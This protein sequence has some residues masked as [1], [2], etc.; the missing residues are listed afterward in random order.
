MVKPEAIE[1]ILQR[2]GSFYVAG[3]AASLPYVRRRLTELGKPYSV[4]PSYAPRAIRASGAQHECVLICG[5][6][7]RYDLDLP[8][9]ALQHV[10]SPWRV[11]NVADD[12]A[13]LNDAAAYRVRPKS[14][15]DWYHPGLGL[16]SEELAA[17]REVRAREFKGEP[18]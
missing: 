14:G 4:V 15:T 5:A 10:A 16:R 1:A 18:G 17:W 7:G 3:V 9:F 13:Y 8:A 11:R 6:M 2:Y 12:L